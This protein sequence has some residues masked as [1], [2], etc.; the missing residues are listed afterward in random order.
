MQKYISGAEGETME[1]EYPVCNYI[2]YHGAFILIYYDSGVVN[3]VMDDFTVTITDA[4]ADKIQKRHVDDIR[5]E[6]PG[7]I[8]DLGDGDYMVR[9]MDISIDPY[10]D[11]LKLFLPEIY[12]KDPDSSYRVDGYGGWVYTFNDEQERTIIVPDAWN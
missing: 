4:E 12:D 5:D 3:V 2:D 9:G 6:F 11:F 10:D 1:E 8:E 7:Y